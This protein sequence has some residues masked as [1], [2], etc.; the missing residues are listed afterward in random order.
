MHLNLDK[1]KTSF[2]RWREYDSTELAMTVAMSVQLLCRCSL[3]ASSSLEQLL[4]SLSHP[5]HSAAS[6]P[7][8]ASMPIVRLW[9]GSRLLHPRA[10]SGANQLWG[11]LLCPIPWSLVQFLNDEAILPVVLPGLDRRHGQG[12]RRA[13]AG[14]VGYTRHWQFCLRNVRYK[15]SRVW[16]FRTL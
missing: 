1:S 5:P 12:L 4:G 8:P 2:I 7:P 6:L 14:G 15:G 13:S 11:S 3:L 10:F 16:I 9:G